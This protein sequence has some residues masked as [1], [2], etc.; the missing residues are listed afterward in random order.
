[1]NNL[2]KLTKTSIIYK[3]NKGTAI[4]LVILILTSLLVVSLGISEILQRSLQVA[5]ISGRAQPAYLAAESATERILWEARKN[6]EDNIT[7]GGTGAVTFSPDIIF[8]DANTSLSATATDE[9]VYRIVII[10]GTYYDAQRKIRVRY[11]RYD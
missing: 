4:L 2:L 7:I 10:T 5:K 6:N 8:F 3:C 11:K 1:M 9:G